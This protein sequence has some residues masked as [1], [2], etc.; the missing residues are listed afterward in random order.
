MFVEVNTAGAERLRARHPW[1]YRG[2]IKRGPSTPGLYPV[3]F[4]GRTIA[5]GIYNPNQT[6][7]LRAYAWREGEPWATLVENL[8]RAVARRE[9]DRRLRPEGGRRLAHAEGDFLPGLIVDEY[10]GHLVVQIG[11]AAL[12]ARREELV[13]TL[14]ELTGARGVLLKNDSRGRLQEGLPRYVETALGEV[15]ELIWIREGEVWLPVFPHSGQ[16]TGAFLDQRENRLYAGA[17]A[18]RLRPE[19]ALDVFSYHGAF[20]LHLARWAK[21][22]IAVDS[23]A[24]ALAKAR[25][26]AQKNGLWLE[27]IEANAF[28]FLKRAARGGPGFDLVVLDPP[29]FARKRSDFERAYRAYKEVNL[30]AMRLVRPGGFLLTAS[31]SHHLDEASFYAMLK[32]AAA[33][34]GIAFRVVAKRGQASDHPVLLNVPETGYLKFAAL[35]RV[36]E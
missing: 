34:V 1:V 8:K 23:S 10:A 31:C 36:V 20:A 25:L 32:E 26:A 22:V 15:P 3:R 4:Q 13:R 24:E 7:A 18:E 2:Q 30:R 33:D 12:E 19:R 29:S 9:E 6:L 27:T 11:A 28:D 21:E 14:A 17:L 5:L 35:E 16:K